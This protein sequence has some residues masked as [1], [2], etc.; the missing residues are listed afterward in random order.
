MKQTKGDWTA[1]EIEQ[2]KQLSR[3][4]LVR[5]FDEGE[6]SPVFYVDQEDNSVSLSLQFGHPYKRV[7]FIAKPS[8]GDVFNAAIGKC[9]CLCKATGTPIP[10]IIKNKEVKP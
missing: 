3:K 2:A 4:L 6:C 10:N 1:E 9:V 8:G 5:L 7:D